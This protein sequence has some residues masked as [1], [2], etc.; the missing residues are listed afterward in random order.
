[1]VIISRYRAN[2]RMRVK[3][4]ILFLTLLVAWLINAWPLLSWFFL[5]L[6]LHFDALHGALL[7]G[8]LFIWLKGVN[9]KQ[10]E[11]KTPNQWSVLLML[12]SLITL[13]T[14]K[15]ISPIRLFS[16]VASMLFFYGLLGFMQTP[17]AWIKGLIPFG[18]LLMTLPFGR[19]LDVFI[20]YPLRVLSVDVCF[21][22]LK[23]FIPELSSQSSLII[24][25]NRASH[26]D[27]DC[28]GLK[29]LWIGIICLFTL[30]WIEKQAKITKWFYASSFMVLW[31]IL[32]NIL[33][34][35]LLTLIH[36]VWVM[37][38]LDVLV[39]HS[40]SVFFLL[41]GIGGMY[42]ILRQKGAH[43]GSIYPYSIKSV[44]YRFSN[45]STA[46]FLLGFL[47]LFT[48][49]AFGLEE[50][51]Q[52][53]L[54]ANTFSTE[55]WE[56]ISLSDSEQEVY[57]REGVEALKWSKNTLQ[58]ILIVNGDWR[59]QH[60]PEL[61]YELSGFKINHM[62]T[63][64]VGEELQYKSLAFKNQQ[65][66]ASF[67][68]Q[69]G[70]QTTDDFAQKVWNQLWQNNATWTLV[71]VLDEKGVPSENELLHIYK[72]LLNYNSDV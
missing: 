55:G 57:E 69:N 43:V 33:R 34:I 63:N 39:H 62:Q 19:H 16:F 48:L 15:A 5:N 53:E 30:G 3:P 36:V 67:W 27:M 25:E 32:G 7:I 60:K 8:I 1:M 21:G 4:I 68:F 71:S 49:P 24:L 14:L 26:I 56:S 40:T 12:L 13:I 50:T 44:R 11:V 61:C 41:S 29:G 9:L 59:S 2:Q 64:F 54:L 46:I 72:I 18:L 38:E 22:I 58:L 37:P 65:S 45:L 23:P 51:K 17:K 10:W 35:L 42:F 31:L 52:T 28:S 66:K 20:G 6:Q 70:A 47:A